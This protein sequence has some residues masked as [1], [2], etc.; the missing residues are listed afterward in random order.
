MLLFLACDE[1]TQRLFN[2]I[3]KLTLA[4]DDTFK[5]FDN[6]IAPPWTKL[7]DNLSKHKIL[8]E[9]FKNQQEKIVIL[10]SNATIDHIEAEMTEM[11][12]HLAIS[13]QNAEQNVLNI[14]RTL[15]KSKKMIEEAENLEEK[16]IDTITKLNV[17][18]TKHVNLNEALDDAHEI[19]NNIYAL[20]DKMDGRN[21][22]NVLY[23]CSNISQQ[24]E[25]IYRPSMPV[26]G[27]ILELT[28]RLDNITNITNFIANR[29]I[30]AEELNLRNSQRIVKL[31]ANIEKLKDR[32]Q[33]LNSTIGNTVTKLQSVSDL[34]DT[35]ELIY[36]DMLA[37]KEFGDMK[38]LRN[39]I[40]RN[41]EA[42]QTIE[43]LYEQALIHVQDLE[44]KISS[45]QG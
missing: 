2:E 14:D 43:A 21:N 31:K 40:R 17:F 20:S 11:D 34:L 39:R 45:Y 26:P 22:K 13:E 1:C 38:K 36:K 23:K 27:D 8:S 33:Y 30:L 35:M 19:L 42:S 6:G 12:E 25:L 3:D 5:L 32:K 16:L 4:V 41:E 18:A 10:L 24:V 29:S 37:I 9:K 15:D 7:A 28:R 44:T